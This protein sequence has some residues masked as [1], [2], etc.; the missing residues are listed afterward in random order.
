MLTYFLSFFLF[1]AAWAPVTQ[2]PLLY[3]VVYRNSTIGQLKASFISTPTGFQYGVHSDVAVHI[4]GTKRFITQ[5][6]S[7]Y[8]DNFLQTGNFKDDLNGRTR[9][10]SHL[11]W[12]GSAYN[13]QIN[14]DKS[15]LKN[16]K[17][18][19]SCT[20]LYHHEPLGLT[21]LFSERYGVYCK[22][23]ALPNHKYELSLPT[24]K[25]NYY[26]YKDGI[27]REVEVNETLATFYF[28]LKG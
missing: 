21:E 24:G 13:I 23:K 25:R 19:Y 27:C 20:N 5:S 9:N 17:V 4:F 2:K 10:A 18:T 3:D 22:I 6:T 8:K 16:R 15:Q 14:D 12:D 28:R 11:S 26:Q 7:T 1:A